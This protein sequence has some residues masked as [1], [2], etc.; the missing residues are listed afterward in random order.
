MPEKKPSKPKRPVPIGT[1]TA[2]MVDTGGKGAELPMSYWDLWFAIVAV[3]QYEGDLDR[4]ANHFREMRAA[5]GG[6]EAVKGK[7]SHLRDLQ[8]RLRGA[9]AAASDLLAAA[10]LELVNQEKRRAPGRMLKHNERQ[11]ERSE[12]MRYPPEKRLYPAVLRQHWAQFPVSPEPYAEQLAKRF[13]WD[14]L[15]GENASHALARKLDNETA[16]AEKLLAKHAVADQR[17]SWRGHSCLP[18][19]ES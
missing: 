12:P 9:G 6:R 18:N 7:L 13:N 11:H 19:G 15:H 1:D 3:D 10:G 14:R 8:H 5:F 2:C 17:S 16:R 4:L